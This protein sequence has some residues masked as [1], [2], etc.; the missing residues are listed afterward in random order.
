M[1]SI[2]APLISPILQSTGQ[3]PKQTAKKNFT[4]CSKKALKPSPEKGVLSGM[5]SDHPKCVHTCVYA[6]VKGGSHRRSRI[7]M[8]VSYDAEHVVHFNGEGSFS[9]PSKIR[10]CLSG[11]GKDS[12]SVP[13]VLRNS[14]ESCYLS[15]SPPACFCPYHSQ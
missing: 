4:G 12:A 10:I 8:T 7:T 9:F 11:M 1:Y 5:E 3:M 15:Q 13:L 2:Y 6:D 14:G